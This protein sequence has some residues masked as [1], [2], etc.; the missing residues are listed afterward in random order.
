MELLGSVNIWTGDGSQLV[1][2]QLKQ[3]I[4]AQEGIKIT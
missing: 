2:V 4:A 1:V 3:Y